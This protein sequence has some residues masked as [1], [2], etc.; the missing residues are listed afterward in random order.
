MNHDF[1]IIRTGVRC[2]YIDQGKTI[3][4]KTNAS[5]LKPNYYDIP[6]GKVEDGETL[7]QAVIREFK[8]ETNLNIANP[9]YRGI[10]NV[11][12]EK[13]A[14]QYHTFLVDT[15]E[16]DF[17]NTQEHIPILVDIDT[18]IHSKQRFACTVMLEPSFLKVLLDQTKTFELTI[19]TNEKE[20]INKI[21]FTIKDSI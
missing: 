8:E 15:Y 21:F 18:I 19:Y 17:A 1:K 13:G 12:F 7:E 16:G 4:V 11:V 2:F 5:N 20:I 10:I 14:Y 3:C 6:G 9:I